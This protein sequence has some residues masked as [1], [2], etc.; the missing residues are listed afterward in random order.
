MYARGQARAT[1]EKGDSQHVA[2]T[3]HFQVQTFEA[4]T[5]FQ[6]VYREYTLDIS[7]T[8]FNKPSKAI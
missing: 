6:V 1:P 3:A 5:K 2:M 8:Q 4:R 7:Q